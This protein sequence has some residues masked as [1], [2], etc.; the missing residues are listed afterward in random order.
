MRVQRSGNE[1]V[2]IFDP[3]DEVLETLTR[4]LAEQRVAA[5]HFQAIGGF[6]QFQLRYF[7]TAIMQYQARDFDQQ[8]EVLSLVGDV[9]LR[10]NQP[11]IHSHIVLGTADYQTLGGHLGHG[12]VEPTLEMILTALDTELVREKDQ[13]TGLDLIRPR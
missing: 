13:R 7:D 8:V 2:L 6:K 4:Y 3:G 10:D 1:H 5:G 9:S 11:F 12:I